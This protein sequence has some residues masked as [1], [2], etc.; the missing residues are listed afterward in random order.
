MT[1]F[2]ASVMSM[3]E[4]DIVLAGGA[5]IIDLKDPRRGALGAL[6][7]DVIAGIVGRL[8]GRRLV[9]A[10]VGD[11]PM[12][13]GPV[14]DAVARTDDLGVDIVKVGVFP[15]GKARACLSALAA[16]AAGGTRLVAV[17]FADQQP[18]F[19]LVDEASRCG[20][21]GVMLDTAGK[22]GGGLRK[23]LSEHQLAGFVA[24]ARANGLVAGLAGSLGLEDVHLLLPLAP[25]YLGFRSALTAGSRKSHVDAAAIAALRHAIPETGAYGAWRASIA[26]A[27]AGTQRAAQSLASGAALTSAAK[28]S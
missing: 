11:L 4:A 12:Q 22:E 28:S 19:S 16:K 3:A 21:F 14:V 5:D 18:D 10:T 2:L 13:P 25:D 27:T 15:G 24:R 1:A 6:A 17:L 9:S 26:T 20:F 23:H 7:P 8:E